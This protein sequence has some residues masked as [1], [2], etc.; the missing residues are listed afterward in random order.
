MRWIK[1]GL[2]FPPP[3]QL[4]WMCSYAAL[5]FADPVEDR[6]KVYFSGRDTEGKAQIG[7]WEMHLSNPKVILRISEQPVV[8]VGRLGAF[9]DGGVTNSWI[10][11]YHNKKYLYYSGWSKGV[12]VPFYFFV[13]VAISEDGGEHFRKLSE[14]P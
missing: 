13:G 5:P 7:F 2:L 14:A 9:D 11:N 8:G 4:S 10:M 1:R 3:T 12:S 6:L